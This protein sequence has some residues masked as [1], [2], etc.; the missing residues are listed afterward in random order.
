[1]LRS[2]ANA[3]GTKY[4]VILAGPLFPLLLRPARRLYEQ[5]EL[6]LHRDIQTLENNGQKALYACVFTIILSCLEIPVKHSPS[7]ITSVGVRDCVDVTARLA[8][9]E[10][11]SSLEQGEVYPCR[12]YESKCECKDSRV[13]VRFHSQQISV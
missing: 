11:K 4:T 10:A 2:L 13:S 5:L 1:M 9:L 8:F 12:C 6:V 7:Y 3:A